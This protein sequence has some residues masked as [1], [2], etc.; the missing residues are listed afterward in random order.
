MAHAVP[1]RPGANARPTNGA[2]TPAVTHSDAT[3]EVMSLPPVTRVTQLSS[4][5][6]RARARRANLKTYVTK[7]LSMLTSDT[8]DTKLQLSAPLR[9]HTPA[10]R[11][12]K[13]RVTSVT[14]LEQA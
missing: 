13:T 14:R 12:I 8:S 11:L 10:G 2:P 1:S 4:D 6:L 3:A 9:A 7:V 5:S